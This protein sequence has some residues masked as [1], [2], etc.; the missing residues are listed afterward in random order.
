MIDHDDVHRTRLRLQFQS[1]LFLQS[2]QKRRPVGV[3]LKVCAGR[4]RAI[5][6]RRELDDEIEL[7]R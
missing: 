1:E 7:F 2:L 3:G 5:D 6:L 4:Q